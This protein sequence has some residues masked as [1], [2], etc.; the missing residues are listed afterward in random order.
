[1]ELERTQ[2]WRASLLMRNFDATG[3]LNAPYFSAFLMHHVMP[4]TRER[5]D[6]MN[7]PR[8]WQ[9]FLPKLP[10]HLWSGTTVKL[11]GIPCLVKIS[12]HGFD[13][14]LAAQQKL[15][16]FTRTLSESLSVQLE[17]HYATC[18][19]FRASPEQLSSPPSHLDFFKDER[20]HKSWREWSGSHVVLLH[21][22]DLL[23]TWPGLMQPDWDAS[24]V[25]RDA[26]V[27]WT[28]V[29]DTIAELHQSIDAEGARRSGGAVGI[30][31]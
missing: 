8:L 9:R 22:N 7:G 15:V 30:G 17:D 4:L 2:D 28:S 11:E 23:R 16:A 21:A 27:I 25:S 1:M 13:A 31:T 19:A 12:N 26:Q 6:G 3:G 14:P 5:V 10:G 20:V 18:W 24:H 29:Q